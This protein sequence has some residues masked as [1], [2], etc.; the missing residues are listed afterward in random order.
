MEYIEKNVLQA[1]ETVVCKPKLCSA[2]LVFAWIWGVLGC[3]L[4]LIPTIKAIGTSVRYATTEM[5]VTNKRV[6]EKYGWLNTVCDEMNLSKIENVTIWQGF[7]GKI[8]HYGNLSIQ[9]T[10]HNNVNFFDVERPE[11]VRRAIDEARAQA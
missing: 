11:V 7:I 1:G 8:F 3:W 9:G 6:I 10:N 2:K 4:L 5:V